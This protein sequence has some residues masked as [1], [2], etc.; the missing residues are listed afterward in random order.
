MIR[1]REN[2]D[3]QWTAR[4]LQAAVSAQGNSRAGALAALDEVVAALEGAAGH[5]P[6]D[7]ELRELGVE[8][9]TA[10][11]QGADLPELLR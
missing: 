2:P 6:T 7:A 4:D 8:P 1:L 3:G 11:T 9:E 5:E 10:R